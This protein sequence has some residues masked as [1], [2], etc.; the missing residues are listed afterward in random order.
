MK[1]SLWELSYSLDLLDLYLDAGGDPSHILT[2]EQL[3]QW[4]S[5]EAHGGRNGDWRFA[6]P[7]PMEHIGT[8]WTLL[9]MSVYYGQDACAL[10]LLDRGAD[11]FAFESGALRVARHVKASATLTECFQQNERSKAADIKVTITS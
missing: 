1:S 7:I 8:N 4:S 2:S 3:E 11:T 6:Y 10:K 5:F 9:M